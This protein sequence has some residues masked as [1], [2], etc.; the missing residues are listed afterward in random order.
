[1]GVNGV[2]FIKFVVCWEDEG[3]KHQVGA[4]YFMRWIDMGWMS[5]EDA[6]GCVV[7]VLRGVL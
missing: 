2:V 4:T 5:I 7:G 1:M 3:V 6:F